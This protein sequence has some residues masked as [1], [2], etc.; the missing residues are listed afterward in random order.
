M[1][2]LNIQQLNARIKNQNEEFFLMTKGEKR[3]IVAQDC[4]DRI[5]IGQLTPYAGNF[6]RPDLKYGSE[7]RSRF[8]G[9]I[10]EEVAKPAF[11]CIGCAKGGMF[12]SYVGRANKLNFNDLSAGSDQND[13]ASVEHKKLLEIFT[14]TQLTMI[15]TAFEGRVYID[16]ILSMKNIEKA[17]DFYR[18]YSNSRLVAICENIIKNKGTFKP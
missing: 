8:E 14:I 7:I 18:K 12:L 16:D 15:E 1:K 10:K 6:L 5:S 17:K 2:K 9:S 3:V 4:I 13:T 11:T